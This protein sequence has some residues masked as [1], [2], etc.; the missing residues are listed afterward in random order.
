MLVV[1]GAVQFT[2]DQRLEFGL[3]DHSKKEDA[4]N[5][6]KRIPYMSGGTATGAAI[7]YT[8]EKLFK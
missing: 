1:A 7:L 4:L 2:Y 8:A 5:A 3:F 6:V